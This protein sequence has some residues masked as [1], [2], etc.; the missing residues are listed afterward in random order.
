VPSRRRMRF[1]PDI[2]VPAE[3]AAKPLGQMFGRPRTQ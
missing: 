3:R 1:A 2:N